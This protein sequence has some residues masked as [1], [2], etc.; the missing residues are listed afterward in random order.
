MS[1]LHEGTKLH[2]DTFAKGEFTFAQRITFGQDNFAWQ[3]NFAWRH[4]RTGWT[5]FISFFVLLQFFIYLLFYYFFYV[6]HR[7]SWE[8][9][10]DFWLNFSWL[11]TKNFLNFLN[12]TF[13]KNLFYLVQHNILN[14]LLTS[15]C[16][17]YVL[18]I[19]CIIILTVIDENYTI[20]FKPNFS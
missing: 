16:N 18:M 14:G 2:E 11:F 12:Q 1:N 19:C 3:V 9:F 8:I 20:N 17:C 6:Y 13:F 4:F 5:F 15:K 10:P 7:S